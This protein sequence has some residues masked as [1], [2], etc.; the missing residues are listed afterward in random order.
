MEHSDYESVIRHYLHITTIDSDIK[1]LGVSV[2][3]FVA[4]NAMDARLPVFFFN[5]DA[6]YAKADVLIKRMKIEAFDSF[7][8]PIDAR[9][10][11]L[12]KQFQ[13][14]LFEIATDT[15]EEVNSVH[16]SWVYPT[17]SKKVESIVAL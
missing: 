4:F 7:G 14:E 3:P 2:E 13:S 16:V 12:E 1:E 9:R 15:P 11:I 17:P 10:F 6:S 5:I 8:D